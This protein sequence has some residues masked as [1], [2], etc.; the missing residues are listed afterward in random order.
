MILQET[1]RKHLFY[2]ADR[3]ASLS[4]NQ[5][6]IL[7]EDSLSNFGRIY[8]PTLKTKHVEEMDSNQ[9]RE[10]HLENIK[11]EPRYS[12]YASR[13]QSI[14][15]ANTLAEAIVFANSIFPKPNHAIPIIEIF[16]DKFWTLDSNW[17][18]YE[19]GSNKLENYRK[20]WDGI[21]SNHRPQVGERRPPRLEVLIPLPAVTGKIVHVVE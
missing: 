10:F 3:S 5:E 19:G 9:Q 6:I 7:G 18:D 21:I 1:H 12:L 17:L 20:Y 2:H 4:E 13:L 11:N 16:A 8:W 15:A 14:F